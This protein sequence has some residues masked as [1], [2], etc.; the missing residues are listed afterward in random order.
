MTF[1]Q[2]RLSGDTLAKLLNRALYLDPQAAE[3]LAPLEGVKLSV[4]LSGQ[5]PLSY[6]FIVENGKLA[7][8]LGDSAQCAV[9]LRGSIW[10]F[11]NAFKDRPATQDT[12]RT[13]GASTRERKFRFGG[14]QDKLYFEG[15]F[16]TAQLLQQAL[17]QLSPD[18]EHALADYF[19]AQL[20]APLS[21]GLKVA[22]QQGQA[23]KAFAKEKFEETVSDNM[24]T[25]HEFNQYLA[26]FEQLNT[27][28]ERLSARVL[29]LESH[30]IFSKD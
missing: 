17:K 18:V 24:L 4:V 2:P 5:A 6:C 11:L 22:K 25:Y 14:E 16:E 9:K 29:R 20:A 26:Q 23:V 28:L 7:H 13:A 19:G 1:K 30:S 27:A 15:D 8:W 21:A 12:E 10:A 3:K